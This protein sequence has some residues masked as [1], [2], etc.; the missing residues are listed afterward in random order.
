MA[1]SLPAEDPAKYMNGNKFSNGN[2]CKNANAAL[3]TAAFYAKLNKSMAKYVVDP[4]FPCL[5][6]KSA[7]Q[8]LKLEVELLFCLAIL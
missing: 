6:F 1:Q 2:G 4:D 5:N 7:D 3:N 8:S